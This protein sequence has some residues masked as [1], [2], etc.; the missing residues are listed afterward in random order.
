V[1]DQLAGQT[2]ARQTEKQ[3][4]KQETQIARLQDQLD[5]KLDAMFDQLRVASQQQAK[6]QTLMTLKWSVV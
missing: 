4:R 5:D 3:I 2:Q 6:S 1:D